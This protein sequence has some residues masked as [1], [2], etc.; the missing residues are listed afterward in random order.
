MRDA[1]PG[2]PPAA[3]R[4]GTPAATP[5]THTPAASQ[6]DRTARRFRFP[7]FLALSLS[8]AVSHNPGPT[9]PHKLSG[10]GS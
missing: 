3:A 8:G 2:R 6:Y 4:T 9:A 10:I 1:P 5:V 7:K